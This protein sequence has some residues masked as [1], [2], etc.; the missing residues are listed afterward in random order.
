ME[1]KRILRAIKNDKTRVEIIKEN[2]SY[3][4]NRNN[5]KEKGVVSY[6]EQ[7]KDPLRNA[8]NRIS[9][10]FH[11]ILVDEKASYLFTYPVL[12]DIDNNKNLNKEVSNILGGNFAKK[13]QY[14]CVEASNCG[15]AWLHYWIDENNGFEFEKV[16][17]EEIIPIYSNY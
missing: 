17:T 5:I 13:A 3:Y 15:T 11:E 2:K 8:D 14:L 12:F 9:H 4:K 7:G 16:E 6:K 1:L 10:N